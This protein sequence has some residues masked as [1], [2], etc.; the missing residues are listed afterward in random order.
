VDSGGRERK[1]VFSAL[2]CLIHLSVKRRCLACDEFVVVQES[3]SKLTAF[4]VN[5]VRVLL[6]DVKPRDSV[7]RG[8]QDVEDLEP[9]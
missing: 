7:S 2:A 8:A 3:Q 5:I 4:H 9:V 6:T 1:I